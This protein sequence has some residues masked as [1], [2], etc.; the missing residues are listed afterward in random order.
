MMK[1][2]SI[3]ILL[4]MLASP[5]WAT[6]YFLATAV[7]GGNDSNNGTSANTPW[8]SPDHTLNCGD[9]IVA[10]PSSSYSA[11]NFAAG[12]WGTV[13]CP[14][15]NNVA[16]LKCA[17]F[18]AC[19]INANGFD[20]MAI[21]ASYWGIQGW[22]VTSNEA[23]FTMFPP[24]SGGASIH[25][26]IIANSIANGCFLNG[27]GSTN[28]GSASE[29]YVAFVG[30]IA[31]NAAQGSLYCAT[32][33]TFYQPVAIDSL[34]GTH[35]YMAGNYSYDNVDPDPCAGR[36]PT[37]GEGILIDHM[38]GSGGGPAGP[39][40]QQVVVDNNIL[41][42]NGLSGLGVGA[43]SAGTASATVYLRHNTTYGNGKSA[44]PNQSIC[45][46]V[47]LAS[48]QKV[49]VLEN[50]SQA[51]F[52]TACT[53]HPFFVHLVFAGYANDS[54]SQNFGYSAAGNNVGVV[55]GGTYTTSGQI[56]TFGNNP[57]FSNPT[58]PGAPNCGS[59]TSVPACMAT[60]VANFRPTNSAA[61]PYGF[62]VPSTVQT[63]DPLFPQWLCNVNLP[64]GLVTMGCVAQTS[65]PAP[66]TITGVKVQ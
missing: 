10:A 39:Y 14:A 12:K 31:Y 42:Y 37:D 19:K 53:N 18:D 40:S 41:I 16:W 48:A 43:N 55:G 5:V 63:F 65:L 52:P 32:G 61:V 17:T 44:S 38:D 15:G 8:L 25:H 24:V 3:V 66:V 11:S 59:F 22:E 2:L 26:I 36:T 33:L 51:I 7:G 58:D 56:N 28:N 27:I 29:D 64:A 1:K 30:N 46:E 6:T 35:L 50:L 23:C 47:F 49:Q 54:V 4:S 20:G 62:Q 13:V 57:G 34:S 21:T 9:V 45:G 60:V